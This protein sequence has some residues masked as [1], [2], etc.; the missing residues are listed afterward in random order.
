[1]RLGKRVLIV[2]LLAGL[3]AVGYLLIEADMFQE[4]IPSRVK[5]VLRTSS[6]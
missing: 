3:I 2:V 5:K 4:N 6:D 1:M